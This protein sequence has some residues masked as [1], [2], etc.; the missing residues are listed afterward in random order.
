MHSLT[1]H[2]FVLSETSVAFGVGVRFVKL[3][4]GYVAGC[5]GKRKFTQIKIHYLCEA[6]VHFCLHVISFR[7]SSCK[8]ACWSRTAV[9]NLPTENSFHY[10]Q[11]SLDLFGYMGPHFFWG[12]FF[13]GRRPFGRCLFRYLVRQSF[14]L[15]DWQQD[16]AR[17][18]HIQCSF[19][20]MSQ[21]YNLFCSSM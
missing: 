2:C 9:Q 17:Y 12:N 10:I 1:S 8:S 20:K 11:V 4:R 14:C 15:K 6:L 3:L 7:Y 13:T 21:N 5:E 19:C 16:L 18:F